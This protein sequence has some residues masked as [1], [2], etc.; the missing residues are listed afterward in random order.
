MSTA[1]AM[2]IA[3]ARIVDLGA[4][5]SADV[6]VRRAAGWPGL[7]CLQGNW[8]DSQ[9]L[10]TSH[11]VRL[12]SSYAALADQQAVGGGAEADFV[13]GGWFGALAF[14]GTARLAFHDHVVR[15]V[16]GQWRFEALWHPSRAQQLNERL[17]A[18]QTL[19]ARDDDAAAHWQAGEFAGRPWL[20]HLGGV[21][22]AIE[23]I[24]AGEL[25]Q[26]N[27]C[28]RLTARFTGSEA[29]FFADLVTRL[30]PRF[31]AYLSGDVAVASMSP[32]LFLER[33]GREVQTAPIKGTLPREPGDH[34][35]AALRRS[36]KDVAENVMIVDLVRNDLGRVCE[37]GTVRPAGL[38]DVEAH[39]GV[40]HLVSRVCGRLRRDV[41]DADLL[42]ATFPPGSVTGAPKIRALAAIADLEPDPR[43][44]YTGAIGFASPTWG[45][46]F[47]VAIRTF[48][49]VGDRVQLG[50]GGGI[51]A[52]SVP[53]LEWRECLHKV[54]PLLAAAGSRPSSPMPDADATLRAGGLLETILGVDGVPVRLADHLARLDRSCRELFGA[55]LPPDAAERV[56]Q[57]AKNVPVGRAVLRVTASPG[58]DLTITAA[59]APLRPSALNAV[60]RVRSAGLWRHKW[61][62][63][64]WT[65][66]AGDVLFVGA[67]GAVLET[68]RGNVFLIEDDGALVTPPLRDE[69][70]PGVTRRAL[71]D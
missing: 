10:L 55:G 6:L 1:Q 23:L 70:L 66:D 46:Q 35:D 22:R 67:D 18:W 27:V 15:L 8:A 38:L 26:V 63:R 60:T 32:E 37:I 58:L 71:L 61:A 31:G 62:D 2:N 40:W 34:N 16:D 69:L 24:R 5:P 14:D 65:D 30:Q 20:D 33:R 3:Q 57:A 39:P 50:V 68:A 28:T 45:T 54:A 4:G 47:S 13:G 49:I 7:V 19:L 21:E 11:P 9:A 41:T 51:T 53:M 43:G 44:T 59:P 29:A 25:Y 12:A 17:G 42:A 36:A 56:T 52:D 64:T 48:E